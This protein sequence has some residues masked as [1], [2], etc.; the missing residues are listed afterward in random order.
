MAQTAAHLVDDV[1]PDV[2]YRQWVLTLPYPLRLPV[3]FDS[4]LQ[5]AIVRIFWR[6]LRAYYVERANQAGVE[7]A[8][9][10]AVTVIQ[11]FG[12]ALQLTPHLH[13][14]AVDGVFARVG[15]TLTHFEPLRWPTQGDIERVV[16]SVAERVGRSLQARGM[17]VAGGR[18]GDGPSIGLGE[19]G[20]SPDSALAGCYASAMGG[21]G[22]ERGMA[23]PN[24]WDLFDVRA[25]AESRRRPELC[26]K[27]NG[28]NLHAGV[29]IGPG[30]RDRLERLCRY[31]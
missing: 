19:L 9:F 25:A 3:A 2:P 28:F 24:A 4:R 12:S 10:G 31:S 6:T 18:E 11:R 22:S 29:T 27:D 5:S 17:L 13:V 21:R 8:E 1:L 26:A 23:E 7:T 14:L 16:G 30:M 20:H 15:D